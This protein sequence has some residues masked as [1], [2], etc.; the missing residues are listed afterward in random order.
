MKI[1]KAKTQIFTFLYSTILFSNDISPKI[2]NSTQDLSYKYT[3]EYINENYVGNLWSRGFN[4]VSM[5]IW[6]KDEDLGEHL[7][8]AHFWTYDGSNN[9]T[10]YTLYNANNGN[11]YSSWTDSTAYIYE[12]NNMVSMEIWDKDE[13]LGE[14]LDQAHFW[15]YDGSNNQTSYT[16]YNANNGNL[17]SSWTDSTAYIY[18]GNNMVS[19]EI[20]DKDEDL[21]EH[22]DQAHFWTYDGSNNQ[23]SYTLYNANNGNLYSSWTDSTAY[24]YEGNNMVSMEIWDKD[25]DLG[26]HLDQAHF[27]TYDGSN[28]QTSY[29]LYNANN[30]NLYSSWTDST[31]YIYEGNNMVSME[32][33]DKDEDLGEHLDQAHFW[34]YDGSNNQTSYTLYNANNGNLYSSWTDSTAYIYEGNNMVSMEIWDKDEDL[35]E[36]LDQAHFWTYD[37]SNNQTSY[38]LYNANNGNLYSSWTDSTAYIYE[39]TDLGINDFVNIPDQYILS[40]PYPN[41][42]NP[43]T[44]I[45]FKI[46]N[47]DLVLI[48]VYDITGREV[49]TLINREIAQGTHSIKWNAN[50]HSSGVYFI[51]MQSDNFTKIQKV[52]LMK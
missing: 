4:M 38:T 33:W 25:E 47:A 18:E 48:N 27:W 20:W 43:N 26:E 16:L 42:F 12:G 11:L 9:Q 44:I 10:S 3:P 22:L 32:I 50:S 13:D 2:I 36:H 19:M 34:T 21:G 31:A 35:G 29:T 45:N 41:P 1:L 23:T 5:E 15:T 37:G 49:T 40:K 17:Y 52:M 39:E 28:N 8:Q 14:H 30:G 6:D 7:D 24:I 51:K 46:P